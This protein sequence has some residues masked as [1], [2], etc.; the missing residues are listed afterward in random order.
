[1]QDRAEGSEAS[2][3]KDPISLDSLLVIFDPAKH[4][5]HPEERAWDDAPQGKEVL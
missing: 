1:M 3:G 4:R 5:R 2:H